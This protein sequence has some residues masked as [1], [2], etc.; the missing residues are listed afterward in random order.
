MATAS[1]NARSRMRAVRRAYEGPVTVSTPA[2]DVAIESLTAIEDGA[3]SRVEVTVSS[4]EGGD[5][6]FVI[7]NPPTLVPDRNGAHVIHGK[8]YRDDPV[9]AVAHA[10]ASHGGAQAKQKDT[11]RGRR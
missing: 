4:P 3:R 8:R 6:N 9:A 10:I 2:G 5:P 1:E 11:R 7:V